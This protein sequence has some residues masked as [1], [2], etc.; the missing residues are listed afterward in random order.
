MGSYVL[1][2]VDV[3][4]DLYG[5]LWV[6]IGP[7]GYLLVFRGSYRFLWFLRVHMGFYR[8]V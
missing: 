1:L 8:F 2:Y 5:S 3:G 7:Y 4:P 6:L